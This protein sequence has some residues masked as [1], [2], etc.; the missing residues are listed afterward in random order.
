[1]KETLNMGEFKKFCI[2]KNEMRY[3]S[4]YGKNHKSDTAIIAIGFSK[5][6]VAPEIRA[7]RLLSE[8]ASIKFENVVGIHVSKSEYGDTEAK[9]VCQNLQTGKNE[10][11][12]IFFAPY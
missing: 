9:I 3:F 2:G 12:Y 8:G 4:T 5:I 11:H 6:V 7:I 1:M 10:I